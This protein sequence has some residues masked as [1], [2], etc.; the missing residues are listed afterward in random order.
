MAAANDQL[1]QPS[2]PL[3]IVAHNA[4]VII[5]G[6]LLGALLAFVTSHLGWL[7]H[8]LGLNDRLV[9]TIFPLGTR[10]FFFT[11]PLWI[12]MTIQPALRISAFIREQVP[13]FC[14]S[15]MP[16]LFPPEDNVIFESKNPAQMTT[17]TG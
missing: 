16:N 15:M 13:L 17:P 14:Q 5:S 8:H 7:R 3:E 9:N 1:A 11:F 10:F 2:L 4:T 6:V 12:I